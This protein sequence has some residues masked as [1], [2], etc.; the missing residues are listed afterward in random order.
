M[1]TQTVIS[2]AGGMQVSYDKPYNPNGV[3]IPAATAPPSMVVVTPAYGAA[4]AAQLTAAGL[5]AMTAA[6][7]TYVAALSATDYGLINTQYPGGLSVLVSCKQVA[8]PA[9][10]SGV[11]ALAAALATVLGTGANVVVL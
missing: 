1:R 11:A 6:A 10:G 7:N 2:T 5:V 4:N 9:L 8:I 3:A